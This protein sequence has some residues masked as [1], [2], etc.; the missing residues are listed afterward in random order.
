M[1]RWFISSIV[2]SFISWLLRTLMN[3][4]QI[5]SGAEVY[6][7]ERLCKVSSAYPNFVDKIYGLLHVYLF[8]KSL[9]SLNRQRDK[10]KSSK[11]S[12]MIALI[13][14]QFKQLLTLWQNQNLSGRYQL[15][16]FVS[17][18]ISF[19][20]SYKICIATPISSLY[21]INSKHLLFILSHLRL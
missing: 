17:S 3:S 5:S 21:M 7:Q 18:G 20:C 4:W 2:I 19:T 12:Q 1:I 11:V 16:S 9:M 14:P 10:S 15:K 8:L 13:G 6:N